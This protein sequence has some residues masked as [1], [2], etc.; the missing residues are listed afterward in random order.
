MLPLISVKYKVME[1][2]WTRH[3]LKRLRGLSRLLTQQETKADEAAEG[4]RGHGGHDWG[5]PPFLASAPVTPCLDF[6]VQSW[7]WGAH[8]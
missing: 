4:A 7:G 1:Y 5:V 3:G 6:F 8:E 2:A